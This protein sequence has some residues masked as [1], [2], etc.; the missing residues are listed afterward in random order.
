MDLTAILRD[1]N[2]RKG[3]YYPYEIDTP[4]GVLQIS[5]R[6][7]HFAT[8]FIGSAEK[9]KLIQGHWKNNKFVNT[10]QDVKNHI[11]SIFKSIERY[12][13]ALCK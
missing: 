1:Y 13:L 4:I 11:K 10:P 8:N 2:I 9:A 7:K 5:L 3:N 6:G 12:K